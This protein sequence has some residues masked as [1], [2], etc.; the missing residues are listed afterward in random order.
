MLTRNSKL[1]IVRNVNQN[2]QHRIT[3]FEKQQTRSE[4][5]N[6]CNNVKISGILNEVSDQILEHGIIAICKDSR[7]DVNPLN[8]EGC[9]RLPL[10]RNATNTT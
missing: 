3:N 2:L 9:H 4:Q 7:I 5:C 8:I 1:L 10:G 6:R